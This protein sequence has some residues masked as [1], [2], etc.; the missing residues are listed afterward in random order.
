[1]SWGLSELFDSLLRGFPIVI[2]K[3]CLRPF[4]EP[5]GVSGDFGCCDR[6]QASVTSKTGLTVREPC[7]HEWE[8]MLADGKMKCRN[9]QTY[10]QRSAP[11]QRARGRT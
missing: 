5:V 9:C 8:T 11:R 7:R 10:K 2:C 4:D 3:P 6:C 1:M